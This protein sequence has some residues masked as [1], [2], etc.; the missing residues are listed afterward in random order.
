MTYTYLIKQSTQVSKIAFSH[1]NL[2]YMLATV[3]IY[4]GYLGVYHCWRPIVNVCA[5]FSFRPF[6]TLLYH[7]PNAFAPVNS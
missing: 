6:T 7:I 2:R 4:G 3:N 5:N 1:A